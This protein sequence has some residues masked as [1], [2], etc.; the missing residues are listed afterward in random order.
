MS[1][2]I[3]NDFISL[4]YPRYC[5][6]CATGLVKGENLVCISCLQELPKTNFHLE[7]ENSLKTKFYGK[8]NIEYALA[9]TR[10]VKLGKVQKLLHKIKYNGKQELG[11]L[12]GKMYA[13]EMIKA[14]LQ[15]KFDVIIPI[16]LHPRKMKKRGYNQSDYFAEGLSEVLDLP[17]LK[18]VVI[19]IKQ[20]ETQTR[21]SRVLRWQNV[22][23]IFIV[24][25][26]YKIQGQ[27]VLLVDDVITT[28]STLESCAKTLLNA[29]ARNI[30][31]AAI[32]VAE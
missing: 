11:I 25:N 26:S 32:A 4:F 9:Y 23:N 31:V 16:P 2:N 22:E 15:Q 19:R 6:A 3:F 12:F 17:W 27:R 8:I 5:L 18:D 24:K 21:K 20:N 1:L 7:K 13:A 29:G 28:G 10:F 30:S 14:D